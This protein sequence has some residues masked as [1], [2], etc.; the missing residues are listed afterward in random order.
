MKENRKELLHVLEEMSDESFGFF[1]AWA[2][3]GMVQ[4]PD[5]L[6]GFFPKSRKSIQDLRKAAN[7][8]LE[9]E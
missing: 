6:G 2:M 7:K 8:Y 4:Y 9:H 1:V 3:G 5:G